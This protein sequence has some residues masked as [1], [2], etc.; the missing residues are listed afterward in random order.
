MAPKASDLYLFRA[1]I[2]GFLDQFETVLLLVVEIGWE[3]ISLYSPVRSHRAGL[4]QL[5]RFQRCN[6]L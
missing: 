5:N 2:T 4:P 6:L 3:W 1:Q